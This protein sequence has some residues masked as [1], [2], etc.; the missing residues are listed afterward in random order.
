MGQTI[1][2][3]IM[4]KN[5]GRKTVESGEVVYCKVNKVLAKEYTHGY[6]AYEVL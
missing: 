1:V 5:S 6:Y 4:A 3:K 2:Q